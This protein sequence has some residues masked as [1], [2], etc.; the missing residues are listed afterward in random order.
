MAQSL[1]KSFAEALTSGKKRMTSSPL[2]SAS[3]V[4]TM[5]EDIPD[6]TRNEVSEQLMRIS[7]LNNESYIPN[8]PKAPG[9]PTFKAASEISFGSS[10]N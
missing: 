6:A 2:Q 8:A 1:E 7:A 3:K 5:E 10:W 9:K 4:P